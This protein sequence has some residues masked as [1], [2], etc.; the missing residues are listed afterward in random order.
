MQGQI[1]V[2]RG[3]APADNIAEHPPRAHSMRPCDKTGRL[4]VGRLLTACIT[5]VHYR[6]DGEPVPYKVPLTIPAPNVGPGV[7]DGP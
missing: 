3:L 6:R 4:F 5:A 7:P 1:P 2:G